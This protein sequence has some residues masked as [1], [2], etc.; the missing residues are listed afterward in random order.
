MGKTSVQRSPRKS[1]C[2]MKTSFKLLL[3]VLLLLTLPPVV[4]AQFTSEK[5]DFGDKL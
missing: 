5:T 2:A 4:Q 1:E 3:P